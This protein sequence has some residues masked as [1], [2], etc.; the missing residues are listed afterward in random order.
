MKRALLIDLY[1]LPEYDISLAL[2]YLKASADADPAVKGAWTVEMLHLPV[3][4]PAETVAAAVTG[5]GADLVG[6]SCYSWNIRA[7]ERALALVPPGKGPVVILGGIEVTPDP[8]GYLKKI[9]CASAVVFGEGEVTFRELLLRLKDGPASLDGV[10]GVAWRDGAALKRNAGRPPIA[11]LST[12][13]SPYLDGSYGDLLRGQDR[14]MVETTRGCPYTCTFCF[15]PR[16][17]AKVRSFPMERAKEEIRAIVAAGVKEIVFLDTN[18]NMDRKR[19]VELW[20]FLASLG[21][22][23]RYAFELRG[24][25]LDAEQARHLSALDYFAE[26]GL[27]SIHQRSLDAVKRW[28]EPKRFADGVAGLL[29]AGIYRPCAASVHGGVS[30]DLMMGLPN[31]TVADLLASFDWV[32]SRSPS[33]VVLTLTKILPGTEL[34]DDARKF[35][36]EF[37]P[38]EQYE[39]TGSRTVDRADI[40]SM[41]RFR[42]AVDFAYNRLH[43]VRT[44]AWLAAG[45]KVPPS[46]VFQDVGSRMAASGRRPA[47]LGVKD[48]AGF[49]ADFARARGEPALAEGVGDRL[50]AENMLNVLQRNRETRRTWWRNLVFRGG[51]RLLSRFGDLPPLPDPMP[52]QAPELVT[53]Q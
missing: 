15:E 22:G 25:L 16:G 41:L 5:S 19:A 9:R 52:V 24:E 34:H 42:D 31:E 23:V 38:G 10:Q 11:D 40:A 13:P 45:L 26:I 8:A 21:G 32:F 3:D 1:A 28:Y 2:G 50:S 27:Q 18:F 48:L 33:T 7:V 37:D 53:Q 12:V 49:L 17:F 36:Y 46:A 47:D 44:V 35:Q 43:A 39:V 6:L 29:D 20:K 4:A 51:Y 30:V 14:V